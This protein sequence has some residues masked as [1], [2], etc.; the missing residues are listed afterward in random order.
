MAREP[1]GSANASANTTAPA[2]HGLPRA[3][4]DESR[5]ITSPASGRLQSGRLRRALTADGDSRPL[6]AARF[7][8]PALPAQ[9][10]IVLAHGQAG[11]C[12]VGDAVG[13]LPGAGAAAIPP[14]PGVGAENAVI[15]AFAIGDARS[16]SPNPTSMIARYGLLTRVPDFGRRGDDRRRGAGDTD[17]S[18]APRPRSRR[19]DRL[20]GLTR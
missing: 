5:L 10:V 15:G 8:G 12:G 3:P 19:G 4:R 6:A 17:R 16:R 9:V 14:V 1:S 20:D 11:R 7:A 2:R 18:T 13:L